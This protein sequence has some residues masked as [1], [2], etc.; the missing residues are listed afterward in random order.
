MGVYA[1]WM[2]INPTITVDTIFIIAILTTMGYSI[3]D[4]IVVLDRIR[5][6]SNTYTEA[7]ASGSMTYKTVFENSLRQTM[8]RSLGTGASTL[9]AI[10]A[11]YVFGQSVMQSFSVVM[12]VGILAGS[13]SSI[14]IAAPLA[15]IMTGKY[16]SEK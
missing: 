14:F 13:V 11:M 5:E 2:A 8:R 3:N 12:G 15:Y 9:L 7:M 16:G 4:T 1:V 10:V 6:N